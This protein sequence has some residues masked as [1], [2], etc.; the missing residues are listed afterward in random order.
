MWPLS[1]TRSMPVGAFADVSFP[2]TKFSVYDREIRIRVPRSSEAFARCPAERAAFVAALRSASRSDISYALRDVEPIELLTLKQ[3][4]QG[5]NPC[6]PTN[7]LND[8]G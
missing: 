4:V 1:A 8:L 2:V 6:T 3:R 7:F 5:S